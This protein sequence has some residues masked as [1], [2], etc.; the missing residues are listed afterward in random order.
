LGS[1]I[2]R[3]R[4]SLLLLVVSGAVL[5]FAAIAIGANITGTN[6]G[7]RID[8]TDGADS[9]HAAGGNDIVFPH[10]GDDAT[11]GG[12]GDD[13]LET[14]NG[15]DNQ[16]GGGGDDEVYDD[17]FGGVGAGGDTDVLGGGAGQDVLRADDGDG[18]D[19]VSG[20]LGVDQCIVDA[21]DVVN[22]CEDLIVG[23]P[24]AQFL[25]RLKTDGAEIVRTHRA[26]AGS[27]VALNVDADEG[28]DVIATLDLVSPTEVTMRVDRATGELAALPLRIEALV[29][30]P[31][32]GTL[33]R[34][35]LN[36]GYD[37]RDSRAPS[38]WGGTLTLPQATTLEVAQDVVGPGDAVT[39]VA[40]LFDGAPLDRQDPMGGSL[41]ST[42]VP[43]HSTLGLTLGS[44]LELRGSASAPTTARG[45]ASVVAGPSERRLKVDASN[46]GEQ[47]TLRYQDP[48]TD[49]RAL[50]YAA[51]DPASHV[52]VE[53]R[54]LPGDG[55][56]ELEG[57]VHQI[58]ADLT[59]V[60]TSFEV[61]GGSTVGVDAS[62][63]FVRA[64]IEAWDQGPTNAPFAEDG[65]NKVSLNTR[66]GRLHLQARGF[67]LAKALLGTTSTSM[68]TAF[69][70]AAAPLDLTVAGGTA[71]EP[72]DIT[73][74]FGDLPSSSTFTFSPLLGMRVGWAAAAPGTD[75]G[76]KVSAK[77]VGADLTLTDLPSSANAC[78]GG[79]LIA[80]SPSAP[81]F[82]Q[83]GDEL[84]VFPNMLTAATTASGTLRM[85]GTVCLPPTDEDGGALDPP[86]TV[87]GTCLGG[88]AP[89]RIELDN[90]RLQNARL[91]IAAGNT[92]NEDEGGEPAEDDLLKLWVATDSGGIK[93]DDLLV[94]NDTS[95]T[96]AILK[97][98]HTGGLPLRNSGDHF[99]WLADLSGIPNTEIRTNQIEC[100]DLELKADLPVLGLTDVLPFP[101]EVVFGDVCID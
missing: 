22:S 14:S 73:V 63:G 42:P 46:L 76:L 30:D 40:G 83:A 21:G 13:V 94:R 59:G 27:A 50:T 81:S 5:A 24:S 74:G 70:A 31:T 85:S 33:P 6:R 78:V 2:G 90:L 48:A 18:N 69:G 55:G 56:D 84:W 25:T 98:G 1:L 54:N 9:I 64:D 61:M 89:N 7:E 88:A 26:V 17:L 101:G 79:G 29:D 34:E 39:A 72:L 32:G 97:A 68:E 99:L 77:E 52:Q 71:A 28:A 87:Y 3:R 8:G 60:P 38:T 53:A 86:G 19:F 57:A 12:F 41:R 65:R 95:D 51:S 66:D 80:C 44:H 16:N 49:G 100:G 96:S 45:E 35:R 23:A 93:V 67:D 36:F 91:E 4:K 20:G 10:G 11:L 47:L 62:G 37:A 75:A 82:F 92:T 58:V 43:A 15:D